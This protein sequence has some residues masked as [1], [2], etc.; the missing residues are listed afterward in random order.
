MKQSVV[1]LESGRFDKVLFDFQPFAG[2]ITEF[3]LR[4]LLSV[5]R[6]VIVL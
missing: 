1:F 3:D 5:G 4:E 2:K 6:A